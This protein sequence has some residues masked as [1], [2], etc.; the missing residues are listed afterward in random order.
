[1][2]QHP[3]LTTTAY[4][5]S[6]SIKAILKPRSEKA[7]AP[8]PVLLPG[9]SQGQGAWWAAVY[10]VAQSRTRLKRLSS[11]SSSKA[12]VVGGSLLWKRRHVPF[13]QL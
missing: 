8:T 1:M 12:K 13:I 11:S 7:M 6:N 3:G 9:E 10:G 5:T 2:H 4:D